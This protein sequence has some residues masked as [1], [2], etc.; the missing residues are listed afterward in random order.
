MNSPINPTPERTGVIGWMVHNKV[1]PNLVMLL[2]LIGGLVTYFHGVTKEVFP[3]FDLDMVTVSVPYP[4]ASPEEI[5]QGIVL[6]VEEAIRGIDGIKEIKATASEGNGR[7]V[8]ELIEGTDRQRVFQ[9]IQ[10]EINRVTTF[11]DDAQEPIVSMNIRRRDVVE[12]QVYG[13]VR[14]NDLR[15]AVEMVRDALLQSDE[16]TQVDLIGV[17]DQEII[18]EIPQETLRRYGLKLRDVSDILRADSLEVPAGSIDSSAGNILV[19]ID[20]RN[21]WA[22]DFA[23]MPIVTTPAGGIV[24]LGDLATTVSDGFEDTDIYNNFNGL[25]SI[26]IK[27]YR[28]GDQTPASV[29]DAAYEIM[30]EIESS[31]PP[32]VW[33]GVT[34]DD[35]DLFK[36]RR[37]LLLK[38]IGMGLVIVL[39]VLGL[40][41]ELRL[42]FWV[43]MGIPISFL[44]TILL[45]PAA[46]MS[47]NM[48]SMF[49]FL[50]S[51]GIVVDDA[52]VVGENVYEYRQRGL[53]AVDAAI[54]GARDVSM[55]VYFAVITNI[56]AFIPLAMIPGFLGK[57]WGVI[58]VVVCTA[59]AMSL[60][61]SLYILPSHLAHSAGE[62]RI[63]L[64][65]WIDRKQQAFS[66]LVRHFIQRMYG[67][68]LGMCL[69]QRLLTVSAASAILLVS[70][71]YVASGRLGMILMP[72]IEANQSV[73]SATLPVGSPLDQIQAVE[74]TL[75]DSAYKV[76]E[77]SGGDELVTGF[78][79]SINNNTVEVTIYLTPPETRPI[80]TSETTRRWREHTPS[81][82]SLETLKFESDRGGP[83]G[84][85]AISVDLSHRSIDTLDRAAERLGELLNEYGAVSEVDDGVAA[86][87]QQLDF[88]I[89]DYGRSLGF[90][91]SEVGRQLRDAYQGAESIKQQRGRSEITV[92][93][94][95]PESERTREYDLEQFIVR[96][97]SGAQVPLK[98]IADLSR[99]NAYTVIERTDGRRTATV[100]AD[101]TPISQSAGIKASLAATVLP[102]LVESFPGLTWTWAGRQADMNESMSALGSGLLMALCV[103]Y[104]LLAMAF[105]SYTQPIVV[106]AAIPFGVIGAIIGHSVMGYSMSAISMMGVIALSGVV[107]N[108]S[109][110]LIVA[111]NNMRKEQDISAFEA[112][113]LAGIRR[114]RPILLT[115]L[116]TFG[117]LA[118]MIF[119]T[120]RQARFMI[121][122]AISL[123]FGI[124]FATAIT[125]CFVP[126][127]YVLVDDAVR[128]VKGKRPNRTPSEVSN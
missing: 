109:L 37:D 20:Q 53:S 55:P 108:D 36:E 58:P 113:H 112:I 1:T 57:I 43:M 7:V 88:K 59:F 98:D 105:S 126:A 70:L 48:I 26:E 38:N 29:A 30:A 60:F 119:E 73:A 97:Q 106:M 81:L 52:I 35:A 39:V 101:V 32:N 117:G 116:T 25:P 79:S 8:A 110:V 2:L 91:G 17:R 9:D 42:A 50:I 23:E 92:R 84:G 15:E 14:E 68:F 96:T 90:T 41:L 54:Q 75:L 11:P 104:F 63:A 114:F 6:V 102:E 18:I 122:M 21:D 107:V 31:L 44:G 66:V 83:G 4:G 24:R 67:P 121:P 13:D 51:L 46:D 85:A 103:I 94:R 49:A 120:S 72:R 118:P 124:L 125:L 12:F 128:L 78:A 61:E 27:V 82:P 100:S 69:R 80:S 65:R 95:L 16:I 89:N 76:A 77:E 93:L 22:R 62:H 10:Q 127:L 47:I 19:R 28:V 115:T 33:W 5:E 71:G 99:G 56:V 34:D 45:L 3:S 123:G 74:R 64:F 87:K 86:G 40:F 111:A